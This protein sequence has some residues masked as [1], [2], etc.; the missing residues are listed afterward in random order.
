VGN[1]RPPI[2]AVCFDIA[3][4]IVEIDIESAITSLNRT[5]DASYAQKIYSLTHWSVYDAY[6]RGQMSSETYLAELR[7]YLELDFDDAQMMSWWN[8]PL[9]GIVT[10]VD[11]V[12]AEASRALR[13]SD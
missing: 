3:D 13:S 1:S 2:Q 5:I 8:S 12:L 10:G 9:K 11:L 7:K 4:V 6:E